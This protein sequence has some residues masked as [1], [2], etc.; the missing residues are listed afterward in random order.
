[1]NVMKEAASLQEMLSFCPFTRRKI[2]KLHSSQILAA[3]PMGIFD[4]PGCAINMQGNG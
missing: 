1:M 2:N 3:P 4:L